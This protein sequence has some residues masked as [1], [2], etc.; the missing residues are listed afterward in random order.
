MIDLFVMMKIPLMILPSAFAAVAVASS[1]PGLINI[2][3][4][5]KATDSVSENNKVMDT[6]IRMLVMD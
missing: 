5:P 1:F 4:H 3:S 6:N 2:T